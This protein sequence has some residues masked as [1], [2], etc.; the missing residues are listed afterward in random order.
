ME[1]HRFPDASIEYAAELTGRIQASLPA[2]FGIADLGMPSKMPFKVVTLRESLL[3]RL[4]ELASAAVDL[5]ASE[6]PV[7]GVLLTRGVMEVTAMLFAIDR[8]LATSLERRDPSAADETIMRLLFGGRSEMAPQSAINVLS[9][10]DTMDKRFKGIRA[11]YEDL[12]E[13]AHPN[14][15][16]LMGSYADVD[17]EGFKVQLGSTEDAREMGLHMGIPA[18][19]ACLEVAIHIYNGMK[20]PLEEFIVLCHDLARLPVESE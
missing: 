6:R 10:L 7:A 11:W 3:H 15:P 2:G 1:H 8:L 18:L 12:S 14:Y 16:G 13:I 5:Y 17:R 19:C 20:K 9:H 4:A